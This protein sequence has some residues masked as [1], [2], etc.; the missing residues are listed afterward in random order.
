[1]ARTSTIKFPTT[2]KSMKQTWL[3]NVPTFNPNNKAMANANGNTK[4]NLRKYMHSYNT[5][6]SLGESPGGG[7]R[8]VPPKGSLSPVCVST[9]FWC[10]RRPFGRV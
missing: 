2:N 10:L 8:Q 9:N 1:M 5:I 3:S 4:T 6:E 7:R